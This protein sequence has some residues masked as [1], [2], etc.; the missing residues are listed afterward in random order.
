MDVEE[1]EKALKQEISLYEEIS[2]LSYKER[3]AIKNQD[4]ETLNNILQQKQQI[5]E[6]IGAI[7]E[8]IKESKEKYSEYEEIKNL[9]NKIFQIA[10]TILN[11]EKENQKILSEELQKF[12]EK[13]KEFQEKKTAKE[14]Y[15]KP[16]SDFPHF[17]D[18]KK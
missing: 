10:T 9:G 2:I 5:I 17:F 3:E 1:F 16:S 13:C 12:V 8:K 18:K 15:E 14:I 4:F 6:E 11:Y 7:E